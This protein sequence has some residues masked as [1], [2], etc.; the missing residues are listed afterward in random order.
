MGSIQDQQLMLEENGFRGPQKRMPPG[1]KSRA[2]VA[3]PMNEKHEEMSH[4]RHCSKNRKRKEMRPNFG[5]RQGQVENSI[6]RV[7]TDEL[8]TGSVAFTTNTRFRSSKEVQCQ[9]FATAFSCWCS[10]FTLTPTWVLSDNLV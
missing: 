5:I 8:P 10:R 1:P 9:A 7:G 6:L 3:R 4:S 2:I